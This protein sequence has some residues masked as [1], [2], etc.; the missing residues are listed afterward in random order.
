LTF[1]SVT[2]GD[3]GG[4]LTFR[5]KFKISD[6][7]NFIGGGLTVGYRKLFVDVSE[8]HNRTGHDRGVQFQ[9]T[10]TGSG[11]TGA[12]NVGLNHDLDSSFKRKEFN[13]TLGWGFTPEFPPISAT[14][15]RR[16]IS[17]RE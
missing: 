9:G 3:P 16:P 6:H 1:P 14:S 10:S 8:Q 7:L 11:F 13:A 2:R 15:T 12:S 17:R 4:G 5:D